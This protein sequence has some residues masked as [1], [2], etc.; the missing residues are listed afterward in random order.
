MEFS[1]MQEKNP[2]PLI[3]ISFGAPQIWNNLMIQDFSVDPHLKKR[4]LNVSND[5]DPLRS[6]LKD[7]L[8]GPP[9][10]PKSPTLGTQVSGKFRGVSSAG[11]HCVP[12]KF[13]NPW[14]ETKFIEYYKSTVEEVLA[15]AQFLGRNAS[16]DQA[17]PEIVVLS[18][19]PQVSKIRTHNTEI[20]IASKELRTMHC[21]EISMPIGMC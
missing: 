2:D 19:A 5:E 18:P 7:G 11:S 3:A 21:I 14:K 10:D 20:C 9:P 17:L 16:A 12:G 4:F 15:K 1:C 6:L 8:Q 13:V